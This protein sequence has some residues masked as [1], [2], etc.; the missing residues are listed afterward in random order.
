MA[1]D[2]AG[3]LRARVAAYLDSHHVMTVATVGGTGNTP[4][5]A[6]VFYVM[7]EKMRLIFLSKI[8][9]LH[10][11]DLGREAPIAVTVSEEYDDWRRI[12][13]VQLWGKAKLLKGAAR[14]NALA[15]YTARFPFVRDLLHDSEL[16]P[17]L[18]EVAVYRVEPERI[19]LTDNTS[20]LFGRETLDLTRD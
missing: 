7:D 9:S 2:D 4:H 19:G 5:A 17:R 11:Q 14:V 20:G 12:Q 16:A 15:T 1:T 3:G 6:H 8:T 13:G 10:G 18:R